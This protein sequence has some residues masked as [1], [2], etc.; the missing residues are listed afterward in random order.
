MKV[1]RR[2]WITGRV[3]VGKTTLVE[4][5]VSALETR[6]IPV[7]GFLT[8]ERRG[9]QGQRVGFD[10]VTLPDRRSYLFAHV[11]RIRSPH[12][13]GRYRL[14]LD[15]FEQAVRPLLEEV[16]ED[17]VL[18]VD[19]VGP[20]E[21]HAPWFRAW[22]DRLPEHPPS[23]S[24]MTFQRKLFGELQAR[25]LLELGQVILLTELNRDGLVGDVAANLLSPCKG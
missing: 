7:Q 11:R 10:L 3:G 20:M 22:L 24:L 14:D 2:F 25:G 16:P 21:L 5:V 4:R 19:E 1:P 17:A 15:M 6:G 23:R 12:R 8:R 13:H 18:V 9:R